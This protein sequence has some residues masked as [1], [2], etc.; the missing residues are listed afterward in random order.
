MGLDDVGFCEDG[1]RVGFG[2]GNFVELPVEEAVV[3]NVVVI[4]VVPP[5]S[6]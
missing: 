2:V 5:T 1:L 3:E 4:V 6:V